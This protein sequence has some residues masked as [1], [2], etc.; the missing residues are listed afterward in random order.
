MSSAEKSVSVRDFVI[1]F[2]SDSSFYTIDSSTGLVNDA[3]EVGLE[4]QIVNLTNSKSQESL[5]FDHFA[6]SVFRNEV[7]DSHWSK[8]SL[9][10]QKVL[11]ACLKSSHTG[12]PVHLN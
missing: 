4:E 8:I 1:P 5:M 7:K 2:K 10:T 9:L 12:Q 11:D 3:R 6:E